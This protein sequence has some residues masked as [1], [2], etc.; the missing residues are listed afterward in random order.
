LS[1]HRAG[2]KKKPDLADFSILNQLMLSPADLQKMTFPTAPT[3]RETN[4]AKKLARKA[5]AL[6]AVWLTL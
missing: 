5:A 3:P 6:L 4:G 2:L 1:T